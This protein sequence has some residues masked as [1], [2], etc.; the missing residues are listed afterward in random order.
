MF[1]DLKYLLAYVA[2]VS[3]IVGFIAGGFWYYSAFIVGF[4]LLPL[5]ETFL[6]PDSSN[7][8]EAEDELRSKRSIFDFL[9]YIN[10]PLLFYI[11]Y[12]F[13]TGITKPGLQTYEYIGLI[14]SMSVIIGATGINVAHELGHREKQFEVILAKLMLMPAL[15]MHFNISHNLGHHKNVATDMD[16]SSAKKGESVYAFWLRSSFF[17][18]L[19]AW[20]IE[21]GRL[22]RSRKSIWS[23]NNQMIRFHIIEL[24]YLI[25][26]Y[27]FFGATGLIAGILAAVGGFLMLESVNY[28]EHYGL[29]RK[30]LPSGRYEPATL[31]HSWNSN[32]ELGRI[33]LYEL[34]RHSDHHYRTNRKYQILRHFDESPQLPYG[35]PASIILSLIPPLWFRIMNNRIEAV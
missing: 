19:E 17:S 7:H 4:V 14:A 18:Y 23:L 32:H 1:R 27:Y 10:V 13:F 5:V 15:Y 30:V 28:I 24:T 2:P 12:L 16:P 35:Y 11:L 21:N 33:F 29:R 31:K 6:P 3:A 9:I 22:K 8:P 25:I 20:K 34:T 26:I